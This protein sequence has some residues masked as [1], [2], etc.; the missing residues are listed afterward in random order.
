MR[1]T[2]LLVP[3]RYTPPP[4]GGVQVARQPRASWALALVLKPYFWSV[5]FLSVRPAARLGGPRDPG[6]SG[7]SAGRV[8]EEDLPPG[9]GGAASGATGEA[10]A[11]DGGFCRECQV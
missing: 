11:G 2:A 1:G 9:V 10:S 5:Q 8:A 4:L 6:S 7:G 3:S